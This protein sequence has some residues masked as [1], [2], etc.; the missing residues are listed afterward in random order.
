VCDGV[1]A[2]PPGAKIRPRSSA[3]VCARHWFLRATVFGEDRLHLVPGRA[4]DDRLMLAGMARPLVHRIAEV[5]PVVQD[6]VDGG[7]VEKPARP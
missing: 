1:I 5:D 2:C 4:I 3:G 6:L 7:A